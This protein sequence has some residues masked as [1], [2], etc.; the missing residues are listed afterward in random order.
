V[1]VGVDRGQPVPAGKRND[2]IA[3]NDR[4]PGGLDGSQRATKVD[5]R[6]K[7]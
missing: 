1:A 6:K 2:Q 3:M 5:A 4:E 7:L